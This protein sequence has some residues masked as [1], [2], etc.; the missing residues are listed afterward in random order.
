MRFIEQIGT[1]GLI[2]IVV[3]AVLFNVFLVYSRGKR[4]R[5]A[6]KK[7]KND[8]L[9]LEKAKADYA[10]S[11]ERDQEQEQHKEQDREQEE[12]LG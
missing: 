9:A 6:L 1:T 2:I 11:S 10:K 7:A 3:L 12:S 8:Q 5:Q 4:M